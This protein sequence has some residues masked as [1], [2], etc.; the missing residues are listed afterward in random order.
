MVSGCGFVELG[1]FLGLFDGLICKI[2]FGLFF[3]SVMGLGYIGI[4]LGVSCSRIIPG[5]I[6][7][8]YYLSGK[9]KTRKLLTD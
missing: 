9:W 6:C 5:M 3:T 4:W 2:G 8:G 1:F 7:V